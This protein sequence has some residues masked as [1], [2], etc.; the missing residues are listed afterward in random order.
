MDVLPTSIRTGSD[1]SS[2]YLSELW[3]KCVIKPPS[4]EFVTNFSYLI[5]LGWYS[6]GAISNISTEKE[7]QFQRSGDMEP[8][9]VS[10]RPNNR[11]V[12]AL[13][14][15]AWFRSHRKNS[16]SKF[17][18]FILYRSGSGQPNDRGLHGIASWP[19]IPFRKTFQFFMISYWKSHRPG[20][21]QSQFDELSTYL[22]T[23]LEIPRQT[24][25]YPLKPSVMLKS[26]RAVKHWTQ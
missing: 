20:Y 8:K 10:G 11:I 18:L 3:L 12:C 9:K 13:Q 6:H 25:A 1:N 19:T 24:F 4:I 16:C 15:T 26:I 22:G 2:L 7:L 5:I 23:R 21:T 17:S 14:S